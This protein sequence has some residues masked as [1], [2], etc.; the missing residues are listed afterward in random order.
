MGARRGTVSW[1]FLAAAAESLERRET[2]ESRCF[3]LLSHSSVGSRS[4]SRHPAGLVTVGSSQCSK[5]QAALAC[6]SVIKHILTHATHAIVYPFQCRA[7]VNPAI[8]CLGGSLFR[9]SITRARGDLSRSGIIAAIE[10][11]PRTLKG[12]SLAMKE[13]KT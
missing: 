1:P 3:L 10:N 8:R 13:E 11:T 9:S 4:P 6:L 12:S 5:P 7:K 2:P